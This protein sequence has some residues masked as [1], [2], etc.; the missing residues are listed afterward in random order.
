[1][2]NLI[3]FDWAMKRLLRNKA[4]F[5]I[6]EGLLSELLGEDLKIDH[7]L[8]SESNK[9]DA[10]NKLNRVDMLVQNSKGEQIIIEVQGNPEPDYLMRMAFGTSKLMVDNAWEG[11]EYRKVKKIISLNIVYFDLGHGEDYIYHGTTNFKGLNK[12]DVLKLSAKE[13]AI[14]QTLEIG[15]IYPEYYI[16]KVN[17]FN[18]I[19]KNTLDEWIN[20]LKNEEVKEGTKAKGLREAK[21]KLDKM[22][23]SKEERKEYER[24]LN[25]WRDNVTALADNFREGKQE[26]IEIG[27][28]KKQEFAKEFADSKVRQEK[29]EIVKNCLKNGLSI[30]MTAT[31]TGLSVEEI[32]QIGLN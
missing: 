11:M 17:N 23:L 3:R 15:K 4:N 25:T 2:K 8:E 19:S 18:D 1:M 30:E 16:I 31:I 12:N 7:L 14:F 9:E 10:D 27:E 28:A 24:D 5:G 6:L 20:F 13:Q 32:R 26:G 22:K 29:I 21:E